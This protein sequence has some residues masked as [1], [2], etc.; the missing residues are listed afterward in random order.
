MVEQGP[1]VFQIGQ[2][3]ALR[4]ARIDRVKEVVGLLPLALLGPEAGEGGGGAEPPGAEAEPAGAGEGV[5]EA[6]FRQSLIARIQREQAFDPPDLR[7]PPPLLVIGHDPAGLVEVFVCFRPSPAARQ[8]TIG[9]KRR[10]E[11]GDP[12]RSYRARPSAIAAAASEKRSSCKQHRPK[13]DRAKPSH[14]GSCCRLAPT[15]GSGSSR[16]RSGLLTERWAR[17]TCSSGS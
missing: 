6:R 14:R 4:E 1:G 11:N 12:V 15:P 8:R 17:P 5:L 13:D 7:L 10:D 2:L 9:M 16:R 3:E